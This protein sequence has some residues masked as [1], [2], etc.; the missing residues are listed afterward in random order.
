MQ[1]VQKKKLHYSGKPSFCMIF[2]LQQQACLSPSEWGCNAEN[3]LLL[4]KS[5]LP[6]QLKHAATS[7]LR[8][9]LVEDTRNGEV[10]K[11][12]YDQEFH[13]HTVQ[14]PWAGCSQPEAREGKE[15]SR[16]QHSVL[17][18]MAEVV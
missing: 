13:G 15:D 14:P 6:S 3:I 12:T 17:C 10:A 18:M 4:P 7:P 11:V 16:S 2:I 5:P 1:I 8:F 9:G